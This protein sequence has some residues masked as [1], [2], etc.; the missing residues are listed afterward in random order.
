VT[1]VV[2]IV[3]AAAFT[4]SF[5]QVVAGFGFALLAVPVMATVLDPHVAVVVSTMLGIITTTAQATVDRRLVEVALARRLVLSA[6]MGMPIGLWVFLTVDVR[7]LRVVL[8]LS[9]LVAVAL[10]ARQLDLSGARGRLDVALGSLSGV[11]AT[12]LSTN[13]PP[14]V[15]GL[16]ARRLEPAPFRATLAAVLALSG[17]VSLAAFVLARQVDGAAVG[18]AAV[19]LPAIGLGYVAGRWFRPHVDP[20][21]FRTLVLVLLTMAGM[22]ALWSGLAA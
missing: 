2:L 11:L 14:L 16:Q 17:V 5:V 19:A 8:G 6:F 21:R 4:A 1:A 18:A 13:G 22:A 10:L 3:L 15:F 20:R 9:V 12:S 7:V